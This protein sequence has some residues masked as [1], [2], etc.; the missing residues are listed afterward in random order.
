MTNIKNPGSEESNYQL[1]FQLFTAG[2]QIAYCTVPITGTTAKPVAGM[3]FSAPGSLG[4]LTRGVVSFTL[5]EIHKSTDTVQIELPKD[6][7]C[8]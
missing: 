6:Y 5:T 4:S 7:I 3:S 1:S 8:S 2:S